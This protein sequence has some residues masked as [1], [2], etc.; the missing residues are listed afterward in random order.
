M[1]TVQKQRAIILKKEARLRD[2]KSKVDAQWNTVNARVAEIQ[3]LDAQKEDL[4]RA[5]ATLEMRYKDS[6]SSLQRHSQRLAE[7]G[8]PGANGEFERNAREEA[9]KTRAQGKEMQGK[10]RAVEKTI[11]KAEK[12]ERRA[13]DKLD[14]LRGKLAESRLRLRV[15]EGKLERFSDR[16][17]LVR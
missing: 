16:Y 4:H 13:R 15:E 10:I 5:L 1:S 7:S 12:R 3:A 17:Q 2:Y 14:A 9:E 6:Q 8:R 11:R